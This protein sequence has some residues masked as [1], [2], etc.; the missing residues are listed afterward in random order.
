MIREWR[1]KGLLRANQ[2]QCRKEHNN[3]NA[4]VTGI[5]FM[6]RSKETDLSLKNVESVFTTADR[7]RE[8]EG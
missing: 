4:V 2:R 5:V 3:S 6:N 1:I 8:R 7:L